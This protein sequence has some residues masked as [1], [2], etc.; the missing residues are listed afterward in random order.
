[1]L[2]R[3]VAVAA[4]EGARQPPARPRFRRRRS[5]LSASSDTDTTTAT[6]TATATDMDK[7]TASTEASF[8]HSAPLAFALFPALGGLLYPNGG[9]IV[10]DILLLALG[11]LFLNWCVRGPWEWYHSAQQVRYLAASPSDIILEDEQSEE[12]LDGR[13]SVPEPSS[14]EGSPK[15]D[16]AKEFLRSKARTQLAREEMTALL[17]CFMGP[18][19]G[20]YLLHTLRSQLTRP[21]EGL[22][23]NYNLT[24]FLLA[25]ELRP[26]AHVIKLK[27]A[28]MLH[29][30]RI[31]RT[32]PNDALFNSD[33]QELLKRV[34]TMEA[35]VAE[36]VANPAVETMQAVR[37]AMQPQLDELNRA[38][39]RY[40][41][42]QTAYSIQNE[43]RFQELDARLGDALSLAAAAARTGQRPGLVTT[44]ATWLVGLA[45]SCVKASWAVVSFPVRTA[46]GV[47]AVVKSRIGLGSRQPLKRAKNQTNGHSSTTPR[48]QSRS[49][50]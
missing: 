48:P 23:S 10:T 4:A 31:V 24:I 40:E 25:A 50:K 18:L 35:R 28:K 8:W 14:P 9:A 44:L 34:E 26:V 6:A 36:P 13:E 49:G 38:M 16:K 41:K 2:H 17:V 33:A 45:T 21:A 27:Q 1:M 7:L 29:L 19:L 30:Q 12:D 47:V 3:A 15:P 11:S 37:Q 22:V 5:L 46:A 43:A 32:G 20:A 39:R 42:R